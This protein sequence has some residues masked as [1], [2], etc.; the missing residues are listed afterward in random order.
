MYHMFP[1]K[2]IEERYV[3]AL[4]CTVYPF[5]FALAFQLKNE[6]PYRVLCGEGSAFCEIEKAFTA[7]ERGIGP[8]TES[9]ENRLP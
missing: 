7:R 1:E 3:T 2:I 4:Q 6:I 8:L 5:V 9:S